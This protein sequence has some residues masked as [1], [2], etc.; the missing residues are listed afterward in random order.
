M[1]QEF[2]KQLKKTLRSGSG[3]HD[4]HTS[5]WPYFQSMLFGLFLTDQ[6]LP[7]KSSG[8]VASKDN[9]ENVMSVLSDD[10]QQTT[11]PEPQG[12]VVNEFEPFNETPSVSTSHA[13]SV[14]SNCPTMDSKMAN[15]VVTKTGY[16]KRVTPQRVIGQQLLEIEKAKF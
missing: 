12:D 7:R 5:S 10:E 8:N 9:K 2:G 15:D 1:R 16:M 11:D 6:F 13:I 14:S 3:A 4:E